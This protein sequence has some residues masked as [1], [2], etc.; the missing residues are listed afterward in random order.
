MDNNCEKELKV[1]KASLINLYKRKRFFPVVTCT[2]LITTLIVTISTAIDERYYNYFALFKDNKYF[3]QYLTFQFEHSIYIKNWI[4]I[5]LSLNL[6]MLIILGLLIERTFGNKVMLIVTLVSIIFSVI[7]GYLLVNF[8]GVPDFNNEP[9][10]ISGASG[11]FYGY[12][13]FSIYILIELFKKEKTNLLKTK[14]IYVIL[15]ELFL[16]LII[17]PLIA[18]DAPATNII[19]LASFIGGSGVTIIYILIKKPK[20]LIILSSTQ[21]LDEKLVFNKLY[22][23]LLL[24]PIF[25]IGTYFFIKL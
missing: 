2:L 22:Y 20:D 23:L 5:H 12:A 18:L 10:G 15:L 1:T 4:F 11:I 25:V 17:T 6:S 9:S 16:M 7:G 24:L 19:H 8:I 13:P 14:Y 21:I 3:F